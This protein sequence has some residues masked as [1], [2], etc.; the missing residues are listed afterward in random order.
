MRYVYLPRLANPE[1][2]A[3]AIS[4]GIRMLTWRQDS[5][6]YAERFDEVAKRYAGLICGEVAQ[7]SPENPGLLVRPEVATAQLNSE[8]EDAPTPSQGLA[9]GA[10]AEGTEPDNAQPETTREHRRLRRF[11]GT[12]HLSPARVGRDAAQIAE[13]VISHLAGQQGAEI[14]VILEIDARL[15]E[16]ASDQVIRVVTENSKSLRF[17]SHGFEEE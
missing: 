2:L 1:V 4:Q 7:I 17:T 8:I 11:H 16:G 10:P 15:P 5:F 6:A 14:T 12:A 3:S 13:E 9:P